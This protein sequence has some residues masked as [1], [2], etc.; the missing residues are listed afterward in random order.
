MF[1]YIWKNFA[2][3]HIP[4]LAEGDVVLHWTR[5]GTVTAFPGAEA[6]PGELSGDD[7]EVPESFRTLPACQFYR[8]VAA[9]NAQTSLFVADARGGSSS[10]FKT[11]SLNIAFKNSFSLCA[12][13]L[14]QCLPRVFARQKDIG[15]IFGSWDYRDLNAYCQAISESDGYYQHFT[16]ELSRAQNN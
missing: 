9:D 2:A 16:N 7:Y 10:C 5:P 4:D 13:A 14:Q 3:I 6:S 15:K 1:V 11:N 12:K 8:Y